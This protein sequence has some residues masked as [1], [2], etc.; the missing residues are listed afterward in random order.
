M[1]LVKPAPDAQVREEKQNKRTWPFPHPKHGKRWLILGVIA[2]L[3]LAFAGKF[4]L[5]QAAQVTLDGSFETLNGTVRSISGSKVVGTGNTVT[6]EVTIAVQNPGGLSAS[7]VAAASI[8]GLGSAG[9]GTFTY[10]SESTVTASASGTAT[11]IHAAEGS[12]VSKGQAL[13]TLGGDDLEDK[14]QN[15]A[16]SLRNAELSMENTQKQL[17]NY[18][19][20]F[21]ISGTVIDKEYKAGDTVESGK[22]LCTIYDLSYLEMTLNIDELDISTVE[23]G[24][25][26]QITAEAVES[27]TFTGVVTRVSVAGNTSGGITSYPVTVRIGESDGLLPGMNVDAEIVLEEASD[28]LAIPSSAVTRGGGNTSLALITQDSPS[29]ENAVKQE[30]P[31]GYVYVQVETGVSDDSYGMVESSEKVVTEDGDA[32]VQTNV[33]VICTDGTAKTFTV[34]KAVDYKAGRLVTVKVSEGSVTIK[35]LTEKHTSG[36]VD[37]AA[38]KLGSLSF[39]EHIEILDTG[40]EGAATSVDVSRLSGMSLDSDDVRYYGLDGDGRIEYLILDDVTGDLWTY[41]YLTDLEDQSQGM[42]INV[43]YTYLVGGAEQTLNSTSAQYPVE[44]GGIAVAHE[45]DG[46]IRTMQRMKSTELTGLSSSWAMASNQKYAV[47]DDVQVYLRSNGSCYLTTLSAVNTEDY[48]L[49]RW[50]NNSGNSAGT[51]IRIVIA[52][53]REE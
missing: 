7:Q 29:A 1:T 24:Q 38:T 17:E 27:K 10:Q 15:A 16:D 52:V 12:T 30:A 3:F 26:V 20:T 31:E 13:V 32:A 46:S 39:A 35:A 45:S 8:N 33:T 36:K 25:A 4:L 44:I 9:N 41:A 43:T 23:V 19:I 2:L 37:S 28:A 51:Q 11:A 47:A 22:T 5:G 42:F 18:T 49:T 6:R 48:T 50:Y 40:D 14:I 53:P 21:P 34:D